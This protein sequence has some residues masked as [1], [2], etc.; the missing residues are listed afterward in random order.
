MAHSPPFA[1]VLPHLFE[2][3][4]EVRRR[5]RT[6]SSVMLF[7]DFDG[8]LV[9]LRPRPDQV[10]LSPAARLALRKLVRHPCL[11]AVIV[12]GRRRATLTR[13][14]QIPNV[15]YMGLY[16]WEDAAG[17][18]LPQKTVRIVSRVR[19][20]LADLP[21]GLPGVY[22]EDKGIALAIH[23]RGAPLRVRRRVRARIRTSLAPFRADLDV[24]RAKEV[25][26]VVPRQVAGKG[27]AIRRALRRV[28]TAFLPIYVG[29]DLTDESAFAALRQGITVLVGPARPTRAQFRLRN[30]REACDFLQRLEAELP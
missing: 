16:G 3:W 30:P 5:V 1:R 13:H 19:A 21:K 9:D 4:D 15:C 8:T 26:E 10:R 14:V 11:R 27:A 24:L 6:A 12:S 7:V 28:R 2:R 17:C 20:M 23:F 29:D 25:W 22:V 18:H